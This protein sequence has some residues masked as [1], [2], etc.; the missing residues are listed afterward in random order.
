[1][2][3]MYQVT[4]IANVYLTYEVEAEDENFAVNE[5][6]NAFRGDQAMSISSAVEVIPTDGEDALIEVFEPEL[7]EE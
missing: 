1:M 4:M 3:K 6:V 5:A 2:K 7:M